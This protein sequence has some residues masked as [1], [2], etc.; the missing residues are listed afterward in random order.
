MTCDNC[1]GAVTA[2]GRR[3]TGATGWRHANGR[4]WCRS[5]ETKATPIV[6]AVRGCQQ[7]A[8]V[9]PAGLGVCTAHPE[10]FADG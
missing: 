7:P 8:T 10:V 5:G 9:H 4:L 2:D 1:G 3:F 6:C